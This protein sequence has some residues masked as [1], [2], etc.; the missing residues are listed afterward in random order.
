MG[1]IVSKGMLNVSEF[2]P[3]T[4]F[5]KQLEY[6]SIALTVGCNLAS[7]YHLLIRFFKTNYNRSNK[8]APKL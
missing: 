6:D 7:V 8:M 1:L 5:F 4:F 2:Q 3:V